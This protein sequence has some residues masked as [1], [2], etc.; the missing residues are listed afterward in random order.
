MTSTPLARR[1]LPVLLLCGCNCGEER[2]AGAHGR[3]LADPSNIDF[4]AVT[5][6]DQ[7]V[8]HVVLTNAGT[9]PVAIVRVESAPGAFGFAQ[10]P[11]TIAAGASAEFAVVFAPEAEGAVQNTLTLRTD[12]DPDALDLPLAGA[13]VK[14][15]PV[16]GV[17]L[18][19]PAAL[20]GADQ[21][22]E[23]LAMVRL[24]GSGSHTNPPGGTLKYDWRFV[25]RPAGSGAT[26]NGAVARPTFVA[27][28][29]GVFTVGLAVVDP[30]GCR[31]AESTVNVN[32]VPR[33]AVHLQLTWTVKHADVD[34][35]YREPGGSWFDEIRQT[36][37]FYSNFEE[38]PDWGPGGRPDGNRRNDPTLD[39]D[40]LGE[41]NL[42]ENINHDAPF[43]GTFRV[44][45][46]YY[47]AHRNRSDQGPAVATLRIFLN[48]ATTPAHEFTRQL[49]Q[50]DMWE[51]ADIVVSGPQITWREI[52]SVQKT[53]NELGGCDDRT[54]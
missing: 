46:N 20:A 5:L 14:V 36:D 35:H 18:R 40:D 27:D 8:R 21:T 43:D 23:P 2:L 52:N 6:G 37:L 31:S 28:A 11:E 26:L 12:G 45:V 4:G 44:G 22:V 10:P 32:V 54:N 39:L 17:D 3:L 47:C 29:A 49:T 16:C 19:V 13:G 50:R 7:A 53:R 48:H 41:S 9:S 38:N 42:M 15:E 34:L 33:G 1:L 30:N 25:S 24:D 51:V